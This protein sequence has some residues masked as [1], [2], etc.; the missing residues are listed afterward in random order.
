MK[1]VPLTP[2]RRTTITPAIVPNRTPPQM[3]RPPFQTSK[4]PCHFGSGTWFHDVR[5]W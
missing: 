5:S 2:A 3:P 1:A 4:T